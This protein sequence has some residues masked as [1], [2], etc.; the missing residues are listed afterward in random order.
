MTSCDVIRE[1]CHQLPSE[2]CELSVNVPCHLDH[3]DVQVMF[4]QNSLLKLLNIYTQKVLKEKPLS[5]DN[6]IYKLLIWLFRSP[7]CIYL[8][9]CT[10]PTIRTPTITTMCWFWGRF[11]VFYLLGSIID[12]YTDRLLQHTNF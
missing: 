9:T 2:V 6:S 8:Y 1:W 7:S 11:L 4:S 10:T 12:T 3:W 5:A